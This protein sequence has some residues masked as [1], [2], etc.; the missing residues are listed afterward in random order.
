MDHTFF[1]RFTA[2]YTPE[3]NSGC[4]LW[5]AA[6]LNAGYGQIYYRGRRAN[7]HKAAYDFFHGP[8]P[9]GKEVHH[10]CNVPGC[11]NPDHLTVVTHAENMLSPVSATLS[12]INA[13]KKACHVGH[14]FDSAN[15]YVSKTGAR[16]CRKCNAKRARDKKR[17][18]RASILLGN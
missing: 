5:T 15:T 4:W 16:A 2:K 12:G 3:P 9:D 7:A 1:E 8:V 13:R 11:V 14:P 17:A 18:R 10:T 6:V